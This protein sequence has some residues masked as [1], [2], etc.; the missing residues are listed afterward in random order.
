MVPRLGSHIGPWLEPELT[1]FESAGD[2]GEADS[3]PADIGARLVKVGPAAPNPPRALLTPMTNCPQTPMG[4]ESSWPRDCGASPA[5]AAPQACAEAA[6]EVS[7]AAPPLQEELAAPQP[8]LATSQPQ[9]PAQEESAAPQLPTQE[10]TQPGDEQQE[11][12]RQ[13]DAG[14][15]Q[16]A[17]KWS[18]RG[19]FLGGVQF[20]GRS[21]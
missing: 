12:Q 6:P 1:A 2:A 18:G 3:G 5:Q 14:L 19:L 21:M 8:A 15:G 4:R 20:L 13:Q 16:R 11:Q 7:E 17:P 9:P 10:A